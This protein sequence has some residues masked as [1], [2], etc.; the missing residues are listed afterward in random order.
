MITVKILAGLALCYG[1]WKSTP[2][3]KRQHI[4]DWIARF[5]GF[6]DSRGLKHSTAHLIK[7]KN[8]IIHWPLEKQSRYVDR[9]C[10]DLVTLRLENRYMLN[11]AN[12]HFPT[13]NATSVG[14]LAFLALY[15]WD[16]G[17]RN[18]AKKILDDYKKWLAR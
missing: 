6:Y 17:V 14:N 11:D 18:K 10:R 9:T 1:V 5:F 7:I 4:A 15:S 16:E 13:Y 12:R 8:Q 2:Q 3:A